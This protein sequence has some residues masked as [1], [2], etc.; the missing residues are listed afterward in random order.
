MGSF[1]LLIKKIFFSFFGMPPSMW[2]FSSPTRDG[3]HAP[4]IARL[5]S[6]SLD[7]PGSR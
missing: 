5:E 4:W 3:T 7:H 6:Y 1:F 2:D